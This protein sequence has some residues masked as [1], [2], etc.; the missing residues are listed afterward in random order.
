MSEKLIIREFIATHE[1]FKC[2]FCTIIGEEE[3]L[4]RWTE[5]FF[6]EYSVAKVK[7]NL[8]IFTYLN[9]LENS[10]LKTFALKPQNNFKR[11][12]NLKEAF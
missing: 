7:R 11:A 4:R 2:I 1:A 3:S 12:E 6:R 10:F 8:D 9:K 5:I